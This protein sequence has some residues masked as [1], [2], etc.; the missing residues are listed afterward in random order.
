M[1]NSRSIEDIWEKEGYPG[2]LKYLYKNRIVANL[3]ERFVDEKIDIIINVEIE[4]GKK[5][6][7]H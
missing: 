6:D 1:A 7:N 5:E 3:K 4:K 2:I